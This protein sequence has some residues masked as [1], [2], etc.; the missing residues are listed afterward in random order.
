MAQP[1]YQ[2][3]SLPTVRNLIDN[4]AQPYYQ[5]DSRHWKSHDCVILGVGDSDDNMIVSN[6]KY[7]H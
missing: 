1:Y 2:L 4:M 7:L 5:L 3:D 6:E